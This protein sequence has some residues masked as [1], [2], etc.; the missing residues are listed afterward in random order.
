MKLYIY[1]KKEMIF[2]FLTPMDLVILGGLLFLLFG[3][4]IRAR[5]GETNLKILLCGKEE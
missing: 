2:M 3:L 1:I 5:E 4:I